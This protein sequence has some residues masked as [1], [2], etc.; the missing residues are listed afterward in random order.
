MRN[1]LND[2][3]LFFSYRWSIPI[4][5]ITS[6]DSTPK[7]TI[8]NYNDNQVVISVPSTVSWVKFNKDQVGYYRVNYEEE[9]W[10]TLLQALKNS[11]EDF[12]T[13]DRAHLLNDANALADAAQLDYTIALDLSTY[14]E[15]EKDYVPW[16]VGTAS[17]TSLKN[18]VYYTSLYK[19][20]TTYARK[21]L[22]PIVEKL[23]FNVG[24]DHLEK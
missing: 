13:A 7:T 3:H 20:F 8:F 21:L 16:S 11:R 4:T 15:E 2:F 24:T 10:K 1:I 5:Y 19:D 6:A 14:L 18:R 17:L 22:S 9:Q 12:S 23:T